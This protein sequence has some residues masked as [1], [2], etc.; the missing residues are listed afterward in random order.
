MT[1]SKHWHG[2]KAIS[3]Q[4]GFPAEGAYL[5]PA[6]VAQHQVPANAGAVYFAFQSQ[7]A[8]V[9]TKSL[10]QEPSK[11]ASVRR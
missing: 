7:T 6:A 4:K 1:S 2:A 10:F 11:V 3:V 5:P 9:K 8:F